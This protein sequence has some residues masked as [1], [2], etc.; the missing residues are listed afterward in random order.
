[1]ELAVQYHDY[2]KQKQQVPPEIDS[3]RK[4][5]EETARR[6]HGDGLINVTPHDDY[7]YLLNR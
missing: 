3:C 5:L 2:L 6:L 4:L 7:L 1:M